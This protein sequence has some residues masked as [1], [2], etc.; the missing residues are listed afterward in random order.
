M[1]AMTDEE[2]SDARRFLKDG[3]VEV[4]IE[5]I[6]A[7]D[8]QRDMLAQHRGDRACYFHGGLQRGFG[9]RGHSP[10]C[11]STTQTTIVA[12]KQHA[13]EPFSRHRESRRPKPAAWLRD[14][15]ARYA[16]L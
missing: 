12:L 8:L 7:L 13:L 10:Q 5:P 14:Q 9:L 16:S 4:E 3:N 2:V 11:G 6:D 15:R 1:A